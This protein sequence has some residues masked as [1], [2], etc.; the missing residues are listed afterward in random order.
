MKM[1]QCKKEIMKKSELKVDIIYRLKNGNEGLKICVL[2]SNR[3]NSVK[4]KQMLE[5]L[6]KAE[7]QQPGIFANAKLALDAGY[8]LLDVCDDHKI[9]ADEADDYLVIVDGNTRFHARELAIKQG[10]TLDYIFQFK[11]Y[12]SHEEFRK[13]Y[14][15]M[16]V[17]NTPT[18]AADFARDLIATSSNPVLADYS[19]RIEDG[20]VPKAAGFSIVGREITKRDL[21]D[22]RYGN[23][24]PIFNDEDNRRLFERLYVGIATLRQGNIGMF[25]GTEI[26]SWNASKINGASEKGKMVDNLIAMYMEMPAPTFVSLL[27]ANRDG[28]RSKETVVKDILDSAFA[29]HEE[30][31]EEVPTEQK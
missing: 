6:C 1:R 2:K 21:T 4:N 24:P 30:A 16:N 28:N 9:T 10:K 20:L 31:K 26:W 12:A 29:K 3:N 13:A 15:Q 27:N 8:T 25:K 22:A 17:Y 19:S 18:S 14:Q 5:G 23:L 11:E 7:M